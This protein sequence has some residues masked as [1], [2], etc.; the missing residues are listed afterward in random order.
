MAERGAGAAV[1][2]CEI[3]DAVGPQRTLPAPSGGSEFQ[4]LEVLPDRFAK[5]FAAGNGGAAGHHQDEIPARGAADFPDM[6]HVYQTRAADAQ[7]RLPLKRLLGLLQRAAGVESL[8]AD[9]E[10]HVVAGS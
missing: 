2:K 3:P 4:T 9:G 10:A 8:A 6:T 7:H 1:L 5:P